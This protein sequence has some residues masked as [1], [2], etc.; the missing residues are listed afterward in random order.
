M[1]TIDSSN[2]CLIRRVMIWDISN[3]P[4][5]IGELLMAKSGGFGPG[6]MKMG[7][8]GAKPSTPKTVM[9]SKPSK[10]PSGIGAG[11]MGGGKPMGGGSPMGGKSMGGMPP[12][13]PGGSGGPPPPSPTAG[14]KK[15]GSVRKR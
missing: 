11:P 4:T 1:T 9:P 5:D 14:F 3:P 15:G 12:P 10:A 7:G 2:P 8:P 13:M 6:A